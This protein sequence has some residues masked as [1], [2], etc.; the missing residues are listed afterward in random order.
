VF[1]DVTERS[2]LDQ[3]LHDK[4]T[5]LESARALADKANLAK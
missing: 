4:N 3:M 5:E 1:R 2:R